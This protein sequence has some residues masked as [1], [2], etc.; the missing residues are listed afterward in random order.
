[1][2]KQF[3]TSKEVPFCKGCSHAR[4]AFNTETALQK[5]GLDPL[6]VIIVT[7]IGCHGIIDK[8]FTTHT[9]HGLH[10]RSVALGAG[11]RMGLEDHTRKVLVFIGDGGATIGQGHILAAAHRNIDMT[12]IVHNNMLYGMTGG[13]S[14]G[15]TPRGFK[16][17]AMSDGD[18][19]SGLD[20]CGIVESAGA[21]YVTRIV[22][23]GDFSDRLAEAI[24]N[25][26][27][28]LVEVLEL[29]PSYGVKKNEGLKLSKITELTGL[30]PMFSVRPDIE[31]F[32][33]HPRNGPESLIDGFE[34][35]ATSEPGPL[36]RTYRIVLAGSAGEGV[37]MAT[38]LFAEAAIRSGLHVTTKGIYPVTVGTGYSCS[39][40]IVS[41]NAIL[42]TVVYQPDA[43]V[44]TSAEGL[45]VC[46]KY[47]DRL[48][49]DLYLDDTVPV[50]PVGSSHTHVRPF[51]EQAGDRGAATFALMVLLT[52]AGL[53]PPEHYAEVIEESKLGST[54]GADTLVDGAREWTLRD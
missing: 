4:I 39:E 17:T 16:T 12:V 33:L 25:P 24:R 19:G 52:D 3:L 29:C 45:A 48:T 1:M 22:A 21:G 50:P 41:P 13:Q 49:G 9:V 15:L 42:S 20:L 51:R 54:L 53:F 5:L 27:F 46:G 6:D 30:A 14:S 10:G 28:S 37:Q 40:I 44:A 36:A 23:M 11:I 2:A 47:L 8:L 32:R 38:R 43:L 7:D 26:G 35:R 18:P 31:P 34:S